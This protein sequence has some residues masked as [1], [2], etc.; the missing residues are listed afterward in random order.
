MFAPEKPRN[1]CAFCQT[2][3]HTLTGFGAIVEE[4][5]FGPVGPDLHVFAA[6]NR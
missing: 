6:H 1:S 4:R 2:N 3:K 5:L